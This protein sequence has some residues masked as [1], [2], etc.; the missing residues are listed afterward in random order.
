[1]TPPTLLEILVLSLTNILPTLTKLHLSLHSLLLLHSSASLY[2][3]L[4]RFLNWQLPVPLLPLSFTPNLTTVILSTTNSLGY[5]SL[6]YLVSSRSRF[7]NSLARSVVKAPISPKSCAI[8]L[9]SY[10]LSTGSESMNASNT[11]SLSLN[12]KV[13]TITQPPYLHNLISV[14]CSRSTFS[15]S[16]VTLARP[17]TSSSLKIMWS[18]L[19]LCFTVSLESTPFISSSTSFYSTSSSSSTDDCC[20]V[21]DPLWDLRRTGVTRSCL[22]V[23]ATRRAAAFCIACS[24]CSSWPLTPATL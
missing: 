11:S 17:P 16:V 3:A 19:S 10:A 9:P 18:L 1:M 12:Y 21:R 8:S 7:Q 22:L 6:N 14:K 4:P 23:S 5:I 20:L 13:L 24:P 15:S 2:P